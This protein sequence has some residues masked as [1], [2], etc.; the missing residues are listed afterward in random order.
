MNAGFFDLST[1]RGG[2]ASV[3]IVGPM[4]AACRFASHIEDANLLR[5][6]R[7]LKVALY[8]S[9]GVMGQG[10][11]TDQAVLLG[12]E[13]QLPDQIAPEAASSR[14]TEI[15][16]SRCL[17][18]LGKQAVRFDEREHVFY[19][20]QLL[21]GMSGIVHPNGMRFQAFDDTNQL[22]VEKDYYSVGGGVVL[23][24]EGHRINGGA[25]E[26]LSL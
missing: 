22:L 11:G 21:H 18:L 9:L 10:H 20:H 13:G 5:F 16:A 23:N 8:G 19:F 2:L 26:P 4:I 7:G 24:R 6:V 3:Y 12:L 1:V 15:K 17:R 14:L 25:Q